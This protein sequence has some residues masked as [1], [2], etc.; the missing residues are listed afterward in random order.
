MHVCSNLEVLMCSLTDCCT[1]LV[2][3]V[4]APRATAIVSRAGGDGFAAGASSSFSIGSEAAPA[5]TARGVWSNR[6][7]LA[8]P[9]A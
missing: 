6:I 3:T 5:F 1:T 9:L 7:S 4:A 8:C 2:L